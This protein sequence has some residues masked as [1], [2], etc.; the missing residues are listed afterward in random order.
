VPNDATNNSLMEHARKLVDNKSL[1]TRVAHSSTFHSARS[2]S[3]APGSAASKGAA[4][5]LA[6]AKKAMQLI[7]IPV[8]GDLAGEVSGIVDK[9]IRGKLHQRR[10]DA[11]TTAEEKVKFKLKDL[12]VEEFDRF[13]W[14][15]AD[16]VKELQRAQVKFKAAPDDNSDV[17][18]SHLELALAVAQA[19]RRHHRLM[20]LCETMLATMLEAIDWANDVNVGIKKAEADLVESYQGH[21]TYDLEMSALPFYDSSLRHG[22]CTSAFCYLKGVARTNNDGS[23][24]R[25]VIKCTK[26]LSELAQPDLYYS[27]S[28]NPYKVG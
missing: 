12:S 17:C 18:S 22:G 8:L 26:E 2:A 9:K 11:A 27:L 10:L 4:V 13:R 21:V 5:G 24:R 25:L 16:S 28:E 23:L 6:V 19:S 1:F 14:K 7:P 3:K 20:E 15:L